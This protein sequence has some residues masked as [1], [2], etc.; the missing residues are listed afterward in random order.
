MGS[1]ELELQAMAR[2]LAL[3]PGFLGTFDKRFPGFIK[4]HRQC[5]AIVNTAD[6]STGG[7]HWLA[8]GWEPRGRVFYL[9]DPFGFSDAKLKQIY[10]FEYQGLMKRSAISSTADRCITFA[11]SDRAVQGPQSAACG[12]FCL[13]FLYAFT[14]W[15]TDPYDHNPV[16]GPLQGVPP[17]QLTSIKSQPALFKNQEF[18]Y[19]FLYTHSPYFREHESE[20]KNNTAFDKLAQ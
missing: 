16:F 3:G 14:R 4:E 13:L 19:S 7:V 6:R 1:S 17:G 11:R 20:I 10:D 5:C 15:P 2:D 9:F 18:V 12:L 8:F